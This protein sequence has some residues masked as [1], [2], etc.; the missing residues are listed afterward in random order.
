MGLRYART[1]KLIAESA[2]QLAYK[3]IKAKGNISM[4]EILMYKSFIVKHVLRFASNYG[5]EVWYS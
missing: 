1:W 4:I 3:S 2:V 5:L